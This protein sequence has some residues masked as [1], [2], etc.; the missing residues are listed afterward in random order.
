[1]KNFQAHFKSSLL[2]VLYQ[3][4]ADCCEITM[5]IQKYVYAKKKPRKVF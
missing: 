4:S 1:M 2:G 3:N 5:F